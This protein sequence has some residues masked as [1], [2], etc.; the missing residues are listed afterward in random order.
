[1]NFRQFMTESPSM[2][3]GIICNLDKSTIKINWH[4]MPVVFNGDC[5]KEKLLPKDT[6]NHIYEQI[7]EK[8]NGSVE[9]RIFTFIFF[10][11]KRIKINKLY[12]EANKLLEVYGGTHVNEYILIKSEV[13]IFF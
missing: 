3:E 6:E 5:L 4:T 7:Q 12:Y 2:F 8:K 13:F 9:S 10:Q 11:N 1:M